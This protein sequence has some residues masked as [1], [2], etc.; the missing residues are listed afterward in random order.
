MCKESILFNIGHCTGES[1]SILCKVACFVVS[2]NGF[3][4]L[5]CM[6]CSSGFFQGIKGKEEEVS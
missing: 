2:C 4:C 5:C 3:C 6:E 1:C